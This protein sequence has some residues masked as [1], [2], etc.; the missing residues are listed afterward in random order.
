MS[1]KLSQIQDW[2]LMQELWLNET[3]ILWASEQEKNA[4]FEAVKKKSKQAIMNLL[5]LPWKSMDELSEDEINELWLKGSGKD[6]FVTVDEEDREQWLELRALCHN[7]INTLHKIHRAS[8][9]VVTNEKW[10]IFLAQRSLTKDTYPWYWEMWWGHT[11]GFDSYEVTL[12]REIEEELNIKDTDITKI[13]KVMKF[14]HKDA[15]QHQFIQVFSVEVKNSAKIA[16][17]DGE[18]DEKRFFSPEDL[19]NQIAL[20]LDWNKPEI[21]LIP[22]QIYC[23]LMYLQKAWIQV[24]EFLEKYHTRVANNPEL[25]DFSILKMQNEGE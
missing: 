10:E 17:F 4:L 2:A 8:D 9:W 14:L 25:K 24:W 23:L 16:N 7:G 3:N 5:E 22:H 13:T 15:Q 12:D 21:A 11:D 20:I 18:I 6:V 1:K 19:L